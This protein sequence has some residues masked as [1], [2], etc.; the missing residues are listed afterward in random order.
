MA[1]GKSRP[2]NETIWLD[3]KFRQL[4]NVEKF[5][6]LYVLTNSHVEQV[7][8]YEL[9]IDTMIYETGLTEELVNKS[10]ETLKERE[11]IFYDNNTCEIAIKN[12]LKYSILTGGKP[13]EKCF[14]NLSKKVKSKELL[15][16]I[17]NNAITLNDDREIY[18]FALEKLKEAITNKSNN[19]AFKTEEE[20]RKYLED[21]IVRIEEFAVNTNNNFVR[22]KLKQALPMP[23]DEGNYSINHLQDTLHMLKHYVGED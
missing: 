7:G 18:E 3:S 19:K 21:E 17:Y 1:I 9:T 22:E 8:I 16:K 13:V 5:L 14:L 11:F 12:Y 6:F 10:L 23:F 2:I 15:T 20:K 4:Q